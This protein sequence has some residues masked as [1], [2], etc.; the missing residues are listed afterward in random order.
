MFQST[1]SEGTPGA[2]SR[3]PAFALNKASLLL[4]GTS[5]LSGCATATPILAPPALSNSLAPRQQLSFAGRKILVIPPKVSYRDAQRET[6][7]PA[8][9]SGTPWVSTSLSAFAEQFLPQQG[10]TVLRGDAPADQEP[11]ELQTLLSAWADRPD[12]LLKPW[13]KER[14]RVLTQFRIVKE[15]LDADAVLVQL[16]D[17]KAGTAATWDPVASGAVTSGTST[18]D[19]QAGL[20]DT[21]TGEIV[22]KRQVFFREVPNRKLLEDSLH[23]LYGDFPTTTGDST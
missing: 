4:L 6:A 9:P 8:N 21:A 11:V 5:L 1:T 17:V 3:H 2:I 7:L 20:V 19:L 10:F 23:T 14:D 22:W 13:A 12:L 18:S 16:L 15:M